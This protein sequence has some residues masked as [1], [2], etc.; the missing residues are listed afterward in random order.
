M[1]DTSVIIGFVSVLTLALS[2][3][4]CIVRSDP[5]GHT[6]W[7]VGFTDAELFPRPPLAPPETRPTPVHRSSLVHCSSIARPSLFHRPSIAR[8]SFVQRS[9]IAQD[10]PV[11]R[12]PMARQTLAHRASIACPSL[13]HP[14][15]ITRPSR[16]NY[17]VRV[18]RAFCYL[19][20]HVGNS[21]AEIPMPSGRT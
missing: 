18:S 1:L 4:R 3:C 11:H 5:E 8:P 9:S 13:V 14:S 2:R 19:L 20:T 6:Q 17:I 7:G 15:S 21:S 16:L 12:A 10:S